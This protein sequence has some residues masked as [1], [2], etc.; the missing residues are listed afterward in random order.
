[1]TVT[2]QEIL[3]LLDETGFDVHVDLT[4]LA[5]RIRCEGI[6]PLD[7]WVLVPSEPTAKMMEVV[8]PKSLAYSIYKSMLAAAPKP[9]VKP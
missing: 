1:M 5:A 9:E 2:N 8:K 7:G 3:D 6:A 4:D